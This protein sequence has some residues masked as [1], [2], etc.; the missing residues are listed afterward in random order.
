MDSLT[1]L[2]DAAKC[3]LVADLA[4][5]FGEVRLKVTGTSMLP[6][7]WPGDEITIER[8]GLSESRV[9]QIVLYEAGDRG[10]SGT[11][12]NNAGP[13]A[14]GRGQ[15]AEGQGPGAGSQKKVASPARTQT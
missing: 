1:Q 2:R 6:S 3:S 11:D 4:R 14:G 10:Q 8:Q 5:T 9:G 7:V 12:A 13:G 15:V